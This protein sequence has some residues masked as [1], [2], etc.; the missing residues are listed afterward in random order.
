MTRQRKK[1]KESEIKQ[2]EGKDWKNEKIRIVP[3]GGLGAIGNHLTIFEYNDDIIIIDAGLMFPDDEMPG[4][5]FLIP[6]FSYIIKNKKKVK[7]IIITHGHEDHIG[8]LPFLL[9]KITTPVY[10]ASLTLGFIK[11]KLKE[12]PPKDEPTL[13]EVAPRDRIE[14][15]NFSVEFIRINH[16]I[17]DGIAVAINTG[18]GTIIHTGD[19]KIDFS[20]ID[21]QMIDLAKFAEYGEKGVLLL[22]SD[23]TNAVVKGYSRSEGSLQQGVADIFSSS[24]GRIIV[25]TFASNIH[26]IQQVLDAAHVYN[27]KVALSGITIEKNFEI[28]RS[29]G[30]LSYKKDLIVDIRDAVNMQDKKIVVVCTGSQG[31][32]MSALYRMANGTHKHIHITDKDTIAISASIIPGNEKT[33]NNVVNSLLRQGAQV[34]YDLDEIHASGHAAEEELKLMISLSKPKF[35]MPIHGEYR[36]LKAHAK[37]AESLKIKQ[38]RI[39]LAD[40]GDILELSESYFKKTGSIALT[41]TF[42]HGIDTGDIESAVIKE[43]QAMSKDGILFIYALIAGTIII[44]SPEII[45]KGFLDYKSKKIIDSIIQFTEKELGKLLLDGATQKD[46]ELSLNKKIKKHIYNLSKRSPLIEIIIIEVQT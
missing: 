1:Q 14:I 9:Q 40:N 18:C 33:V 12:R 15:G 39:M 38:S 36:H 27:R 16:S 41:K 42:V 22:M 25:A 17:I 20:P 4:I 19:F 13:I 11:S 24:R 44:K 5:D 2:A 21:S 45:P 46:I 35:F 30:Y 28:A 8:G 3:L 10:A 43:R 34:F 37:I 32:P 7:G 23:S 6:D 31:E 29:L 26:R